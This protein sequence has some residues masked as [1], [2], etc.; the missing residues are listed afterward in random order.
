MINAFLNLYRRFRAIVHLLLA[1]SY[2]LITPT[3]NKPTSIHHN[4]SELSEVLQVLAGA[5]VEL[6]QAEHLVD[7]MTNELG[8]KRMGD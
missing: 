4:S 8:I 5:T 7:T 1:D 2:V 6:Y 3:P